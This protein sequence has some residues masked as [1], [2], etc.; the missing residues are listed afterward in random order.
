MIIKVTYDTESKSAIVSEVDKLIEDNN[1]LLRKDRSKLV[2]HIRDEYV[3]YIGVLSLYQI[4]LL[5]RVE[6]IVGNIEPFIEQC[7]KISDEESYNYFKLLKAHYKRSL[8]CRTEREAKGKK[9]C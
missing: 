5:G 9:Q 2:Y 8:R 7:A 3:K 6:R 1:L 4:D